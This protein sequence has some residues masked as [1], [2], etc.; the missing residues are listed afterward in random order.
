MLA[1]AQRLAQ[2]LHGRFARGRVP[3]GADA[4]PDAGRLAAILE[5]AETCLADNVLPFWIRRTWDAEGGGFITHLDRIGERLGPTDKHLVPQARMIW[6]L[7]AAHR[8]GLGGGTYLELAGRGVRFMTERMW[9]REHGGF[10]WTV[11]RDGRILH[12]RKELFGQ[13]DAIYALAEYA[14]AADDRD[15]L[16]WAEATFDVLERRAADGDLGFREALARDWTPLAGAGERKTTNGHMHVM[17]A[18]TSLAEATGQARH[19]AALARVVDLL[20]TKALHPRDRYAHERMDRAWRL[21]TLAAG[22][23]LTSYGHNVELAWLWLDA[24]AVLGEAR[25]PHRPALLGLVDHALYYGFDWRRGGLARYGP[26]VGHTARAVYLDPQRLV[27]YWW[28]QVELL[29]ATLEAYRWTGEVLYLAAFAQTWE[30]VWRRQIDH[31]GGDFFEATTWRTGRPLGFQKGHEWKD[32]YHQGRAL[33][34][35]ARGLRAMGLGPREGPR[36]PPGG[37]AV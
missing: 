32:P 26:P 35:V 27:K 13:T 8:H 25:E 36:L 6:T 5:E 34:R 18:F 16:G 24:L 23:T 15:T 11:G 17:E 7:A 22:R 21:E 12:S 2:D 20:R 3:R 30:W 33:M 9:D 29:V 28:V 37:R 14:R 31:E 10:V 4:P 1:F 19:R